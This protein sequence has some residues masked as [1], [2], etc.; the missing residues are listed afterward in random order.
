MLLQD[1]ANKFLKKNISEGFLGK[2]D[3]KTC[4]AIKGVGDFDESVKFGR[5]IFFR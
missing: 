2:I 3:E 4:L 5:K 1:F